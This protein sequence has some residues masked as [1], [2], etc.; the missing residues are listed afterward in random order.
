MHYAAFMSYYLKPTSGNFLEGDLY[1]INNKEKSLVQ[2][3]FSIKPTTSIEIKAAIIC[4]W[5]AEGQSLDILDQDAEAL[6]SKYEFYQWLDT[7]RHLHILFNKAQRHRAMSL[8]EKV[9][10]DL[11]SSEALSE[12]N[13]KK[14]KELLESMSKYLKD[15]D[16]GPQTIINTRVYVPPVL[17]KWYDTHNRKL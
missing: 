9:Y 14:I 8:V 15:K 12:D 5:V 17:E 7:D 4:Q 6:P 1:K 16:M 11:N 2:R 13:I 10:N 3:G